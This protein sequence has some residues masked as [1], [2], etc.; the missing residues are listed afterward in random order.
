MEDAQEHIAACSLIIL[1]APGMNRL[2]FLAQ[3]RP[4]AKHANKVK[5]LQMANKK[6]N[7]Q[8]AVELAKRIVEVKL[9]LKL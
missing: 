4:L 5:S 1:H 7:H 3:G 8:E 9:I 6:A 2:V